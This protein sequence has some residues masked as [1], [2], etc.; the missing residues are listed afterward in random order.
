MVEAPP[1]KKQ[2]KNPEDELSLMS[3][4]NLEVLKSGGKEAKKGVQVVDKEIRYNYL[5]T[6]GA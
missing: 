6:S 4:K 2:E 1:V 3:I 5:T